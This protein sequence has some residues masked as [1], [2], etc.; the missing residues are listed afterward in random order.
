MLNFSETTGVDEITVT[1]NG[2]ILYREASRVFKD[3]MQIAKTFHRGS[4]E[5]GQNLDGVPAKV[6]AIARI[7]WTPEVID[8]YRAKI[9]NAMTPP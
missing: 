5:P 3:G 9:A 2:T 1:E 7:A 8:A 6:A 4:L